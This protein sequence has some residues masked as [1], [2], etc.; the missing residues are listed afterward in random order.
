MV[1]LYS[2]LLPVINLLTGLIISI[3]NYALWCL[4]KMNHIACLY[5]LVISSTNGVMY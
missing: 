1:F 3:S 2:T 5:K 4:N